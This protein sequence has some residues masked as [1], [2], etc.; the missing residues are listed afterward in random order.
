MVEVGLWHRKAIR[1]CTYKAFHSS[2]L[3]S[4]IHTYS[5]VH[6]KYALKAFLT[7][8][9]FFNLN[10]ST[11]DNMVTSVVFTS[12]VVALIGNCIPLV[13]CDK[14][15]ISVDSFSIGDCAE[16]HYT[17]PTVRASINLIQ[18]GGKNLLLHCAYRVD[19]LGMKDTLLLNVLFGSFNPSERQLVKGVKSTPG[20]VLKFN[21]CA[22][23]NATFSVTLNGKLLTKYSNDKIDI[24]TL[25]QVQ[26]SPNGG[27]AEVKD[28]CVKY[29]KY[30]GSNLRQLNTE[31]HP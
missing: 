22:V 30:P 23:A 19:Y 25:R 28:I 29:A 12:L 11:Q 17:A 14:T 8:C 1:C 10:S 4:G 18:A 31:Y 2:E 24:S 27:E 20:T 13:S 9:C 15:T 21:I 16:V 7:Y 26:F 5:A 3:R 6:G